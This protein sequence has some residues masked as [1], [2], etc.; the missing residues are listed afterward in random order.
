MYNVHV[1]CIKRRRE[2]RYAKNSFLNKQIVI[3]A[4]INNQRK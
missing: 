1:D 3:I 4:V 2:I